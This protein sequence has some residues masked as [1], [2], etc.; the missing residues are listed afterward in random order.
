MD[1]KLR[2]T[3]VTVAVWASSQHAVA[4]VWFGGPR[5]NDGSVPDSVLDVIIVMADHA[6]QVAARKEGRQVSTLTWEDDIKRAVRG[7]HVLQTVAALSKD[8]ADQAERIFARGA[9]AASEIRCANRGDAPGV[10]ATQNNTTDARGDLVN[11]RP[12]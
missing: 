1:H 12:L 2:E 3:A 9:D 5:V 11:V 4:E 6:Q 8:A 10:T 7:R